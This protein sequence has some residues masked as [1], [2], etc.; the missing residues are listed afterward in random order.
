MR[1][2]L[3]T[4]TVVVSCAIGISAEEPCSK[5][6]PVLDQKNGF[7]DAKLGTPF[8]KFSHM[9]SVEQEQYRTKTVK[10]Y[11]RSGDNLEVFGRRVSHI[12]YYFFKT[13]CFL[14]GWN[15]LTMPGPRFSTAS[16]KRWGANPAP[17]LQ[18]PPRRRVCVRTANQFP[19][20]QSTPTLQ[21]LS[22]AGFT[23]S[24]SVRKKQF[25]LK[26]SMKQPPGSNR[27]LTCSCS[28]RGPLPSSSAST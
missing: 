15:G 5:A 13:N 23:S 22:S 17:S 9:H 24:V 4:A 2:F 25:R 27:R 20:G 7:R 16:A 18:A 11:E 21:M 28:G 14:F 26:S 12:V 6:G 19:L 10:A 8:S 3:V 1:A